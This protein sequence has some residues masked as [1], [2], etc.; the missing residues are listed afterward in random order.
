MLALLL[1]LCALLGEV[2]QASL[3]LLGFF[4]SLLQNLFRFA[5]LAEGP[6]TSGLL[7]SFVLRQSSLLCRVS[8]G[9]LDYKRIDDF[10]KFSF[11]T[12]H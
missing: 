11:A 2:L 5:Q 10:R 6:T 4:A 9:S 8:K 12:I 1:A 7:D 3:I